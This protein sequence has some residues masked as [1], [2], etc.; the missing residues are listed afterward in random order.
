M[1]RTQSLT[2]NVRNHRAATSDCQFENARLRGSGALH[3]YPA[4]RLDYDVLASDFGG[5]AV[6]NL[7]AEAVFLLPITFRQY[8]DV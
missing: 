2:H 6:D 8:T 7:D 3:C 5:Y 1:V 4:F